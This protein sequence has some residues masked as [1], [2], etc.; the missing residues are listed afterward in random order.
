MLELAKAVTFL[1]CIL[2]IYWAAISAFFV[3]GVATKIIGVA[4]TG[5]TSTLGIAIEQHP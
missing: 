2:S 5:N 1:V 4:A 3:P